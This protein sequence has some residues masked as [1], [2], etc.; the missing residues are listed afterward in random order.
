MS[1][2]TTPVPTAAAA[3]VAV[4]FAAR[5]AGRMAGPFLRPVQLLIAWP[6]ASQLAARHNAKVAEQ[7]LLLRRAEREEVERFLQLLASE[8][9]SV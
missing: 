9:M 5:A 3:Q 4:L 6:V 7:E 8:R 2:I 1:S